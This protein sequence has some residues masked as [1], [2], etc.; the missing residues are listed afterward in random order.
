MRTARTDIGLANFDTR[1]R[2]RL[3]AKIARVTTAC[4]LLEICWRL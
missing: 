1:M 3:S 4:K 2:K